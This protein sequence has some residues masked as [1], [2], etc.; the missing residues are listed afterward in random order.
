MFGE[1]YP[2]SLL[3][4]SS[5]LSS[6]FYSLISFFSLSCFCFLYDSYFV[7]LFKMSLGL[8]GAAEGSF[9]I[10]S[11]EVLVRSVEFS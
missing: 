1:L 9:G 3:P 8:L 11:W 7:I 6:Y 2:G 10:T 5:Y 4:V